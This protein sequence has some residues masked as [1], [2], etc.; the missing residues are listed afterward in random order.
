MERGPYRGWKRQPED[1]GLYLPGQEI[2]S[3]E[4][5]VDTVTTGAAGLTPVDISA[6]TFTVPAI[7]RPFYL[8]FGGYQY[9]NTA[10]QGSQILLKEDGTTIAS[11]YFLSSSANALGSQ[12]RIRRRAASASARVY[13]LQ[14]V[15][16]TDASVAHAFGDATN[17]V[18]LHAIAG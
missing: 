11:S 13:K 9:N 15:S 17:P 16:T 1:S 14:I 6:C 18:Y 5:A 3:R 2:D 7:D 10:G 8:H 12:G 4:S